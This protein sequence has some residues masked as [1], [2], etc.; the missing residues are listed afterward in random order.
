MP[1]VSATPKLEALINGWLLGVDGLSEVGTAVIGGTLTDI[2]ADVR[3]FQNVELAYGVM[4]TGS[5]DRIAGTGTLSFGLNNSVT[6]THGKAGAYSPGHV[7]AVAGWEIG[8]KIVFSIAYSGTTYT[9][10]V[11]SLSDIS[12]DTG[13][14]RQ[15]VVCTAT[16]W[17]DN[18]ARAKV[19][20]VTIQENK[21]ADQLIDTLVTESV[22]EPPESTSYATGQSTFEIAFDNLLDAKTTVM[23]GLSDAVVSELGYLYIKGSTSGGGVLTM[24]SRHSRPKFGA[25]VGS[26]DN[27][28]S[29]LD[30]MRS[31]ESLITRSYIVTHPRTTGTGNV[32]LYELTTTGAIP[33]IPAGVTITINC[34]FKETSL[35]A[36][37][38]A[39]SSIETPVSGTDWIANSSSDGTGTNLT[40]SVNV[41]IKNEAANS[42]ELEITNGAGA[43]AYVTTLQLRGISVSDVSETVFSATDIRSAMRYGE[44]DSRIDMA[45]EQRSGE[46]ANELASYILEVYKDPGYSIDSFWIQSNKSDYLMTQSLAREPGDKITF[47]ESFSGI[48]ET[49][50]GAPNTFFINGCE[51]TVHTPS[52][53]IDT[54]WILAPASRQSAWVL[55]QVGASE[56]GSTTNLGF[57]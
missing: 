53:M 11:G 21:R 26:F 32:V 30:V 15:G 44:I 31:R 1:G 50:G 49:S 29:G 42:A 38:V 36:Y 45:Y 35:N 57:A 7:D 39:A 8:A 3:N 24:E 14:R 17:M 20:N 47:A 12:P 28:M 22:N 41:T 51:M 13:K 56:L 34:P 16:D 4:G 40:T 33:E 37:R 6:N 43:T 2:T 46:F 5:T 9:K 27:T 18:A 52:G 10:F 19:K 48:A 25:A 23:K 55:D 54:R